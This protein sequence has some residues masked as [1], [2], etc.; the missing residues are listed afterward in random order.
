M[1][2]V[3]RR[4]HTRGMTGK[5]GLAAL[6]GL[7]CLAPFAVANAIVAK[8]VEPFFS[9][10]RPGP[11][12][13]PQE[14]VLL[15]IVLCL[16]P[17]GAYVAARPLWRRDANGRRRFLAVNAGTAALLVVVFGVLSIGLGSEIYRCEILR[18]PYCD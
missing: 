16:M 15:A 4:R 2:R 13:S 18:V 12:T 6:G 10:I 1:R 11:H 14:L 3:W 5:P 7:L 17:V 8:Q 9:W